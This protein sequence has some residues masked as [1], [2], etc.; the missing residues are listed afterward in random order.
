[1]IDFLDFISRASFL[2]NNSLYFKKDPR[3]DT[4]RDLFTSQSMQHME[5]IQ[6]KCKKPCR[7]CF[8]GTF[9]HAIHLVWIKKL[10]QPM[11]TIKV[12]TKN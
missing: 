7:L 6:K 3:L 5:N 1:M 9:F 12:K 11:T 8:F 10:E 4:F 2:L